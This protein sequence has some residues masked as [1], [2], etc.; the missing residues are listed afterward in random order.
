MKGTATSMGTLSEQVAAIV[1]GAYPRVLCFTCLA[2]HSGLREHDVRAMALVLIV[3]RGL[4]LTRGVCS[5]CG[6]EHELLVAQKAA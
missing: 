4:E 2:A 5:A 3:R 6:R 1:Y